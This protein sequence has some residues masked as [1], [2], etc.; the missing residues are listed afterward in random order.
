MFHRITPLFI[1]A[2]SLH[3]EYQVLAVMYEGDRWR[4]LTTTVFYSGQTLP[5]ILRQ[6]AVTD[7]VVKTVG[8]HL[9]RFTGLNIDSESVLVDRPPRYM[10]YIRVSGPEVRYQI[11]I[12]IITLTPLGPIRPA[13]ELEKGRWLSDKTLYDPALTT[14]PLRRAARKLFE[15]ARHHRFVER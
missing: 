3:P 12:P 15:L 4:P 13:K 9:I 7:L 6:S 5:S 14:E 8:A 1:H 10:K 11:H 2:E